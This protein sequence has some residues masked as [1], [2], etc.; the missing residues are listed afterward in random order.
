MARLQPT[1]Y[2]SW[3][4][5]TTQLAYSLSTI[6]MKYP[7]LK[8][9]LMYP[10]K[11]CLSQS[12]SLPIKATWPEHPNVDR[13]AEVPW[14]PKARAL[15]SVTARRKPPAA[16]ASNTH[17]QRINTHRL[18]AV[19]EKKAMV[20]QTKRCLDEQANLRKTLLQSHFFLSRRKG[21]SGR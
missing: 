9:I 10:S 4:K 20:D 18:S 2:S 8:E 21:Q 6:D 5:T 14:E 15:L 17:R 11:E 1:C 16:P 7:W 13:D 19:D 12:S 3:L